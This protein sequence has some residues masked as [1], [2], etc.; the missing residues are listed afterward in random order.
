MDRA[1]A[2]AKEVRQAGRDLRPLVNKMSELATKMREPRTS[3]DDA[4]RKAE[5]IAQDLDRTGRKLSSSELKR[6]EDGAG[7]KSLR[8]SDQDFS[9]LKLPDD[10]AI[11]GKKSLEGA[12]Q[13]G[14]DTRALRPDGEKPPE[15]PQRLHEMARSKV[16]PEY[17]DV[18]EAYWKS[19]S[20]EPAEQKK[21]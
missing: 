2:A 12:A 11:R 20:E 3:G 18:L 14:L 4:V 8:S 9:N 10:P 19:V 7:R 1:N 6:I 5:Q 17:R 21:K 16:T 15:D 13:K